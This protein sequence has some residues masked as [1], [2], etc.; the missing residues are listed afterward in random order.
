VTSFPILK[1]VHVPAPGAG[2]KKPR[3]LERGKS[4]VYG[5]SSGED[6]YRLSQPSTND[7]R[8]ANLRLVLS[9]GKF[10]GDAPAVVAEKW[11]T[12]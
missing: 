2:R 5:E 11:D 1:N 7:R 3:R 9:T 12:D 4:R 8:A 6:V 10:K